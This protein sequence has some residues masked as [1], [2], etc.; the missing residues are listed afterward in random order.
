MVL[1]GIPVATIEWKKSTLNSK[2]TMGSQTGL[3]KEILPKASTF[4]RQVVCVYAWP[5]ESD[6]LIGPGYL[7]P[8]VGKN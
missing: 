3:L 1:D 7:Q 5:G 4:T 8:A 6:V 2:F